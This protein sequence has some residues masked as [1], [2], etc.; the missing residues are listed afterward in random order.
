MKKSISF[1]TFTDVHISS[2]NP[3]SRLGDYQSDIINKLQQI[4]LAGEKL[5]VNFFVFG[6]D[7]FNLKAPMRNPHEINT[8]LIRLFQSFPAPIY[9]TEGNHDLRADSYDTFHEQPISVIYASKAL[10]Q[11]RSI[12]TTIN[13]ITVGIRSFPF[14]EAPDIPDLPKA[15]VDNQLN[16][17][18]LHLYSS[19]GGGNLFRTKIYTYDEIGDLNDDIFVMGHYHPDQGIQTITSHGKEQVFV[20]VGALSRGSIAEDDIK[21]DPKIGYVKVAIEDDGKVTYQAQAIKLNVKPVSEAFNIDAK[22][23]EEQRT[24][25]ISE[26]VAE[27][28]QNVIESETEDDLIQREVAGMKIEEKVMKRVLGFIAEADIRRKQKGI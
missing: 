27:L 2:I 17:C 22:K 23:E 8:K 4:K 14:C 24:V 9:A 21:R 7:L 6:G 28:S 12:Q 3:Q 26:F 25:K 5:K 19:L 13:G 1:L 18:I 16:I 11:A 15:P 10:V 20:N